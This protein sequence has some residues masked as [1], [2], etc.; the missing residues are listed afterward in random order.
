MERAVDRFSTLVKVMQKETMNS[1]KTY[2]LQTERNHTSFLNSIENKVCENSIHKCSPFMPK[3]PLLGKNVSR[4]MKYLSR[5]IL[6]TKILVKK[7]LID[8]DFAE[9]DFRVRYAECKS[10]H[11]GDQC[12]NELNTWCKSKVDH[13]RAAK[14]NFTGQIFRFLDNVSTMSA[15]A[16]ELKKSLETERKAM[17]ERFSLCLEA[18]CKQTAVR[19]VDSSMKKPNKITNR[20]A[21]LL[22]RR[23]HLVS[24]LKNAERW[25]N[26]QNLHTLVHRQ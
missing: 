5:R 10:K 20:K 25:Q 4:K 21:L 26:L 17:T 19:K 22:R 9:A 3:M 13:F 14:N 12:V 16:D 7:V 1:I 8:F 23:E 2:D 6:E 11:Y 24:L 18:A 15:K